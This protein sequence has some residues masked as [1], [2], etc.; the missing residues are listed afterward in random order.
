VRRMAKKVMPRS[1][2]GWLKARTLMV[3]PQRWVGRHHIQLVDG[4]LRK[5]AVERALA[6]Q[7][8]HRLLQTQGCLRQPIGY[9]LKHYVHDPDGEPQRPSTRKAV[10]WV[11]ESATLPPA[12]AAP[13]SGKLGCAADGCLHRRSEWTMAIEAV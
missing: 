1:P 12:V 5:Q 2:S 11:A 13:H 4:D 7:N 9:P 10:V 6:A 8:A 3:L